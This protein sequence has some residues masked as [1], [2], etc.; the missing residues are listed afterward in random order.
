MPDVKI[1]CQC[2]KGHC[3]FHIDDDEVYPDDFIHEFNLAG[4]PGKVD[5]CHVVYC[6]EPPWGKYWSD[7]TM[8]PP[9]VDEDEEDN[10]V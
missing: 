5:R 1:V 8:K 3:E 10:D 4:C 2:S 7:G 9:E 6:D